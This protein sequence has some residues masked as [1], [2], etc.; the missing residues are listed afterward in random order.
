MKS[1]K[2]KNKK[3]KNYT[4]QGWHIPFC[5]YN[6]INII[7]I[8]ISPIVSTIVEILLKNKK[9]KL[10]LIIN[11]MFLVLFNLLLVLYLYKLLVEYPIY[12]NIFV[13]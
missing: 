6:C 5:E 10:I 7:I 12:T 13:T 1:N 8:I 2:L 3:I 11:N 9:I 4:N